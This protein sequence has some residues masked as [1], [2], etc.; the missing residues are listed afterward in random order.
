MK[1]L[2]REQ[3]RALLTPAQLIRHDAWRDLADVVDQLER[4][5]LRELSNAVGKVRGTLYIDNAKLH[6]FITPSDLGVDEIL[7]IMRE[8]G[9]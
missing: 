2:T 3:R 9:A 4:L 7:R 8:T 1:N 6:T 5:G